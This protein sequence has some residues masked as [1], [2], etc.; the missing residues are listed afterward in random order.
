MK[1]RWN[2]PLFTKNRKNAILGHFFAQGLADSMTQPTELNSWNNL[3]KHAESI[4]LT[5]IDQLVRSTEFKIQA[6]GINLDYSR[7]R[8]NDETINLLLQLAEDCGLPTKIKALLEGEH[9]NHSERRPALHTALRVMTDAP[10]LVNNTDIIPQIL[11]T[12]ESMQTYAAEIRAGQWL[13]YTGKPIR[14]IVNIGI[15][16]SDFG[17]RFCL[18]ALSDYV[19]EQLSY[20]FIS[21]INPY[22]FE[23]AVKGLCPETTLFIISSKSFTTMETL[24]NTEKAIH[25]FDSYSPQIMQ[26]HFIAVTA[27]EHQAKLRGFQRILP[28]WDWV[29]GRYSLCSAINLISCIALGY[30]HFIALLNGA[31]C[32]DNHFKESELHKNMPVIL[33]LIGIWNINFLHIPSLL[34]QVYAKELELL[35]PYI[36]QLDMES[37]GKSIDRQGRSVNYS[38]GPIIWGGLGNQAQ[39]S[40][41]QLLCQ[42]TQR[43]T[44]DFISSAEYDNDLINQLCDEKIR[45]LSEGVRSPEDPNGFIPGNI[46]LNHL[47]LA[48]LSPFSIGALIAL[49]E[50]KTYVQSVL[51]NINPFDQ[52]GVDSAKRSQVNKKLQPKITIETN[53][54]VLAASL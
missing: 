41:H 36:Q 26:Q 13:G 10:L 34:I 6:A 54:T 53:E 46:P 12:R 35:V 2:T 39:H 50:H 43:I 21:D 40:Y 23:R 8:L 25:W 45:L 47:K 16:G 11:A 30:D 4:R 51:W 42:G 44:S 22:A 9:V 17:P 27:N 3:E 52:P 18:D 14:A 5:S 38:T 37:N 7:Q 24:H 48:N 28:L 20:H 33:A 15:G 31:H 19:H 1:K 49:Y 29:G 32:M